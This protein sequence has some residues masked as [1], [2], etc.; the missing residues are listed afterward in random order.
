MEKR[1]ILRKM[2][3]ELILTKIKDNEHVIRLFK[4]S[5][6][7]DYFQYKDHK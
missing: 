6:K 7:I 2:E 1:N 4:M 3:F 5:S